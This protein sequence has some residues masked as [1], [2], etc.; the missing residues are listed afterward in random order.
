MRGHHDLLRRL[1]QEPGREYSTSDLVE[2]L[3]PEQ[4]RSI[5]KNQEYGDKR[6]QRVA[7]TEKTKLHRKA[8]YHIG[9]L[10]VQG[11]LVVVRLDSHGE[12]C[13][14]VALP[15]ATV[16]S[17]VGS[18]TIQRRELST[19]SIAD[20]IGDKKCFLFE[21]SS[22]LSR[23]EACYLHAERLEGLGQLLQYAAHALRATSDTLAI[24]GFGE[25]LSKYRSEDLREFIHSLVLETMDEGRS[26]TLILDMGFQGDR[27]LALAVTEIQPS[28]IQTIL[29]CS[30]S[31]LRE[32]ATHQ[33]FEMY[34]TRL[35][36]LAVTVLPRSTPPIFVGRAGP[37]A[38]TELGWAAVRAGETPIVVVCRASVTMDLARFER[39][40]ASEVVAL[41]QRATKA[42]FSIAAQQRIAGT[43]VA[44]LANIVPT[45]ARAVQHGALVLRI[46]NYNWETPPQY[47]RLL[48]ETARGGIATHA[49][50]YRA[51]G[52]PLSLT[53]GCSTAFAKYDV[54]LSSRKYRKW[55]IGTDQDLHR[56]DFAAYRDARARIATELGGVDRLRI[57]RTGSPSGQEVSTELAWITA[58]GFPLVTYE[59][60]A[61]AGVRTLTDFFGGT[62]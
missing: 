39:A 40:H 42:V 43:G 18:H 17:A 3:Y 22:T 24:G 60:K 58:A 30:A 9:Q 53:I 41:V 34:R 21:P 2:T 26:I 51:C 8:L 11:L 31:S 46:W 10:V 32:L 49:A 13:Y 16:T 6:Q 35:G 57:F 29:N 52:M 14:Q 4:W 37:Y 5:R 44:A 62:S 33:V 54:N 56:A 59:F 36:K 45:P 38:V 12:K 28:R 25:M 15:S 47:L 61:I 7:Q 55:T 20:E 19:S 23:F 48:G 1:Q 50:V 27:S